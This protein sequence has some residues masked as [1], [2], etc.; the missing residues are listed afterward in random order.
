MLFRSSSNDENQIGVIYAYD[1]TDQK[2]YQEVTTHWIEESRRYTSNS[3]LI[4]ALVGLKTDLDGQRAVAADT[5]RSFAES[6]DMLFFEASAK[7][8][9]NVDDI[10]FSMATA[11]LEKKRQEPSKG[12]KET[13]TKS[14]TLD[15]SSKQA[16]KKRCI[17]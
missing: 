13:A 7:D 4:T 15:L 10:F 11:A 5:A 6:K 2:S 3:K 16:G 12:D 9:V 1:I 8:D 14:N 17:V